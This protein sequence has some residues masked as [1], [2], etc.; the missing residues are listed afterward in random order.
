MATLSARGADVMT[1]DHVDVVIV[2]A[3]LA[4]ISA[5]YYLQTRCPT[6]RYT[7]LEGRSAIGGTWHLFRYPG[8][9]SDSDMYTLGYT[10]R[11]WREA[12]AIADG[13][14]I[15]TYIRETAEEYGIDRKI[16]FEHQVRRASWSSA[17]ATWTVE[18]ERGPDKQIV[19]FTCNFLYMCSGYYDYA[20]G[21][22]PAWPGIERFAGRMVHP[23]QWPDDLDYTGKRVVV[24]GSGATAVTLAPALAAQ[25]AH[26]TMLQRSPSYIA[27][28]PSEDAVAKWL[29]EHLP[30]WVA[31]RIA[32]W[33][34]ILLVMYFYN[35][36]RRRPD[37]TRQAI[38]RLVQQELGPDYDVDTHFAP[39]YNPWDQRLCLVPDGDLFAAIR[40]GKLSVVTD[41]IAT[42]T[43][44][45]IRLRSGA[46]LT[47]DIIVTATGLILKLMSGVQL[48]VDGV[49]V[50]LSNRLS[51]KGM[52]YSD[53]PNLA[54]A[55]GYTNASWTLRCELTAAYVCRLLNYMDRHG[56][57]QGTPRRPNAFIAEVPVVNLSSGY[58]QRA[59]DTLPRQGSRKPWKMYQNYVRDLLSVRFSRVD[60]GTMEFARRGRRG[61]QR[62]RGGRAWKA[63]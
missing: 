27:A 20:N 47:A 6:K 23:Q 58:V 1:A 7:I 21:Y 60:D 44:T 45:G 34:S 38:M 4:G 15:L 11:P 26:V 9:R 59:L 35:L 10:F 13:P 3:G 5:A 19:R 62:A 25:A 57:T 2:G 22:T 55:F 42:F 48:V 12:K 37:F 50:E 17:D 33:K 14:S 63:S 43:E 39:R 61:P 31:H 29:H 36:A 54:S 18:A 49:P 41:Q 32:R 52:M 53:I 40:S 24:I 46:E 8:V 56:Y 30:A 16:Q 51:Y 28:T